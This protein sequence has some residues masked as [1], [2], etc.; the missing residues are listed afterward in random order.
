MKIRYDFKNFP[1][2]S[3]AGKKTMLRLFRAAFIG[4]SA[5]FRISLSFRRLHLEFVN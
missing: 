2:F 1:P 4:Q 3:K 5:L